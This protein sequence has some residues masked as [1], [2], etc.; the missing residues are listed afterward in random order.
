MILVAILIGVVSTMEGD[1][2]LLKTDLVNIFE[3]NEGSLKGT[4][5]SAIS[6]PEPLRGPRD[7]NNVVLTAD[8]VFS[9]T[10][11][12]RVKEH[13]QPLARN[14]VLNQAATNKA[15]DILER[16]YFDHVSPTGEGPSD[17]VEGVGYRYITVGENLA[18]GNFES[19]ADLVQAWMDSP[20]H[21]ANILSDA[22]TQI[23]IAVIQ[24]TYEGE[25]TWVGVQTF[26]TPASLCQA[27]DP[28]QHALIESNQKKLDSLQQTLDQQKSA[29][30][31]SI[32]TQIEQKS[33][34]GNELLKQGNELI[35]EG[36]E[37]AKNGDREAAQEKWSAGEAL[38]AQG[39]ALLQE[40]KTLQKQLQSKRDTYNNV[41]DSYNALLKTTQ[42]LIVTYNKAVQ[43]FNVCAEKYTSAAEAH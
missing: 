14:A 22:F 5:N 11:N 28:T 12:E 10:N 35:Q 18:L 31:S 32:A 6:T 34:E 29:S 2:D 37:L 33:A 16:Q 4:L 19:D 15:K 21:R 9:A 26:G 8:G 36:N 30:N 25:K 27:P 7:P 43:N 40:A 13:K 3:N 1:I 24:G 42:S 39:N 17:V 23:G 41:V 38:Q 20:G